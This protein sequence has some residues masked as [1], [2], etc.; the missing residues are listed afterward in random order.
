MAQRRIRSGFVLL[1]ALAVVGAIVI[2]PHLRHE[3]RASGTVHPAVVHFTVGVENCT[4]TDASRET[5]NYL[6][7]VAKA[8][9]VLVTEIRYP[10]ISGSP[11]LAET[12]GAA[13]AIRHG[14]FP[15]IV[16]AEGYAVT[17][18][19]YSELLDYW[20]RAGFVVAAVR[21]PDTDGSAV[22]AQ[23]YVD[24]EAD[25]INQPRD[26]GFVTHALEADA[27]GP[28]KAACTTVHRLL[29]PGQVALTGQSDGG[30]TMAGLAY[31]SNYLEPGLSFRAVASLSGQAFGAESAKGPDHYV[32]GPPLLVVQSA[33]DTCNPPQLSTQLYSLVAQHE[34]WF[35]TLHNAYHL[36]PYSGTDPSAFAVVAAVT[37]RFFTLEFAGGTPGAGFISYGD[38]SPAVASMSSGASPPALAP[39]TG[40]AASCYTHL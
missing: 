9:R 17:P 32:P 16:F 1:V 14:P 29:I 8:G 30:E 6:T 37:T 13:P 5:A 25:D 12:P 7:G 28:A 31:D 2:P 11:G 4:F 18:A 23:H 39:L 19:T 27:S 20:V 15:L 26:V 3:P 24:T 36:P 33:T 34:K 38:R 10:T 21:F 22:A 35:L 40:S